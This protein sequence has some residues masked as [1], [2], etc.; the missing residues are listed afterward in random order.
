MSAPVSRRHLLRTVVCGG[1]AAATAGALGYETWRLLHRRSM[2]ELYG[3]YPDA[4]SLDP[5]RIVDPSAPK[6]NVIVVYCDDLGYGDIGCYG[7]TAIRTPHVDRLAGQGLRATDFYACSG[8]CAPSRAGL[9]TGR[10]PFRSG[11]TGNPYPADEARA[12]TAIRHFGNQMAAFGSM[13]QHEQY[14][15]AGLSDRE[16]T[17]AQALKAAGYY[18]A[19]IGKWHLG[20]FSGQPQFNPR[21]FGFDRYFGVPHSND[22]RPCPLFRDER[23][24]V[25]DVLGIL[26]SITG[27]YTA[28]AVD[29][30]ETARGRPFF[31]YLAHTM[32]HQPLA[33]SEAF[34]GRSSAGRFGDAVEE[35][36]WSVG[37]IVAALDRTGVADDTLLIFTSDNGP[38]YEGSAGAL[39]GGKGQSY[40]GAFKV[41]FVARWP[42]RIGA[43]R[44]TGELLTNLDLFPTLLALAGLALPRDRVIDGVDV[45]GVLDGSAIR[46]PRESFFYYHYDELQAVRFRQWKYIRHTNRYVW[47]VPL[48]G[49]ALPSRLGLKQLGPDRMPLLYDLRSDPGER[50]NVI[51]HQPEIARRLDELMS[52]WQSEQSRSPRGFAL[53]PG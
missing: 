48:D 27:R 11:M 37:Q 19:M 36:D 52:A 53:V 9:L 47:P 15:T 6:P 39:R 16:L 4:A 13:D 14:Y 43:G 22:M 24:E 21:R 29:V 12:Q 2:D 28:E 8:I 10:Y 30:I 44:V 38:W 5:P 17:L 41:P 20:D 31:L 49:E 3:A 46:S 1:L 35:L 18:T 45:L 42:R 23:M 25:A 40:D 34:A 33:A 7:S 32:P 51:A 50:Y 26:P